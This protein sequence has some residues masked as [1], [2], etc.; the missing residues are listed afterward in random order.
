MKVRL[1]RMFLDGVAGLIDLRNTVVNISHVPKDEGDSSIGER[2]VPEFV[3]TYGDR[4]PGPPDE[5]E[6]YSIPHTPLRQ[7]PE[8]YWLCFPLSTVILTTVA[9]DTKYREEHAEQIQRIEA[10]VAYER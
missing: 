2:G 5:P 1:N 9:D 7:S 8:N 10:F 6:L 3:L 4:L